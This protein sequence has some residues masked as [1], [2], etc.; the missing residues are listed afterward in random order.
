[1]KKAGRPPKAPEDRMTQR[2]YV[3]ATAKEVQQFDA[4]AEMFHGRSRQA[5]AR[6]IVADYM[7][8]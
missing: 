6:K 3:P 8:W 4:E 1:M 5:H 2:I 7:G